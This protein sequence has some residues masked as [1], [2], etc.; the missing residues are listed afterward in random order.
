MRVYAKT[1]VQEEFEE[2]VVVLSEIE[3]ERD[4]NYRCFEP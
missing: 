4:V 3:W 1:L 2:D